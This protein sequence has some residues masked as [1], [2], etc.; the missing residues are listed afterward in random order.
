MGTESSV[1][2]EFIFEELI[3]EEL[4]ESPTCTPHYPTNC[5]ISSGSAEELGA[6]ELGD[7]EEV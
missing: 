2:G 5:C 6:E 3:V 4:S 7:E 1:D